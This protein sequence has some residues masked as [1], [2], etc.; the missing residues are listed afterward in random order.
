MKGPDPG[1]LETAERVRRRET[2]AADTIRATLERLR[3]AES[4]DRPLGATREL[5]A[6]AALARAA[7]ID[8][9][10]AKGED[11]G[12]LA[13]V[14][15]LLKDNL[16]HAP[17]DGGG[18]TSAG[19]RFLE[20]Y[21]SPYTATCVERLLAAGAIVVG[22]ASM[23]EFG[24]GS[25][26][27]HWAVASD[28]GPTITRNPHDP[29]F[30]PGGSSSGSAAAVGAGC[31][32]LSLGSDTGGS[33][34]QPAAHCGVVGYKPSY[35]LVSR[36]GLVAFASS[37]D[38]VGPIA[39]TVEDA[40]LAARAIAGFDEKDATSAAAN[41]L[42][43]PD[44]AAPV[45][46][47]TDAF[48]VG[49]VKEAMPESLHPAVR[50]GVERAAKAIEDAGGRVVEVS[51][52]RLDLAIDAYYIVAPVEAA[53][54]LARY[55]GV[56]YGRRAA[57]EPGEGLLDLYEKSRTEGFGPEVQRRVVLGTWAA[58]AGYDDQY[59]GR[60]MKARRL[61]TDD[62]G[63]LLDRDHAGERAVDA[64][65][66]PT[67]P[68]PAFELGAKLGDPLSM[69]LEDLYTVAAN[70]TG[71]CAI[72]IPAGHAE[73]EDGAKLPVGA[74]LMAPWGA[75]AALLKIAQRVEAGVGFNMGPSR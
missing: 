34:R 9:A 30:V 25:S 37:L 49:L 35:G 52:P 60:A 31:V 18:R 51:L 16:C 10:V 63:S 33:I 70:L 22:R 44:L 57:L 56:R 61:L 71:G 75:D 48:T 17:A 11:P 58:S 46:E 13:G 67:T 8:Q 14:P 72:S 1:I 66:L 64:L 40:A 15:V 55:D 5:H 12:P 47:G 41:P 62:L 7:T 59:Y 39:R 32:P 38:Q 27:E 69:Y 54:N 21:E 29:R 24:M 73:A 4:G 28:F 42:A 68:G 36:W 26:G 53:S 65:L 45:R 6:E 43:S 19:S 74:Q 20:H 50:E 3:A 2:S 23:D